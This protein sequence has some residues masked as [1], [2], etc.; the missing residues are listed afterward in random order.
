M[1]Q[2]RNK[3][4]IFAEILRIAEKGAK[5]TRIVYGANLNFK[6]LGEYLKDLEKAG[7]IEKGSVIKT[8][9]RGSEYLQ[10][11]Y[12]LKEFSVESSVTGGV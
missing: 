8:T 11:F 12:S 4:E 3:L 1:S 6:T 5:K 10:R 2:R 9:E 7:L